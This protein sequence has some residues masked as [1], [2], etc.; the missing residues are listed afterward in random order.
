[1]IGAASLC[2]LPKS[3]LV[4]LT[5]THHEFLHG[6]HCW[7]AQQ[8]PIKNTAGQASSGTR[9][10]KA[11]VCLNSAVSSI[12]SLRDSTAFHFDTPY[13]RGSRPVRAGFPRFGFRA[14]ENSAGFV[15]LDGS[16]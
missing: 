9:S 14:G 4:G 11:D 15:F 13:R 1:M 7:L 12:V 16:A 5:P 3:V 2:R 6:C 8:C 10:I